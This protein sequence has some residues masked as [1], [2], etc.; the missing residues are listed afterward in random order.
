MY[1]LIYASQSK[2]DWTEQE[3]KNLLTISR[4]NNNRLKISG[5]L[6]F[7]SGRFIQFLEGP[8]KN[9][10]DLFLK[11]VEDERHSKII[12]LLEGTL[13]QRLFSGWSMG[14][15][16]INEE[17]LEAIT[18]FRKLDDILNEHDVTND[19]HPAL[20][21]LKLFYDKNYQDFTSLSSPNI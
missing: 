14:F 12:V 15:K 2:P 6:V 19:S 11:I 1:Y 3:L 5:M 20:I 21:F 16:S 9:V 10:K 4:E 7:L 17:E 8:E 13:Q 18:G